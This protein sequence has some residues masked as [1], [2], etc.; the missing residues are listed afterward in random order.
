ML[1]VSCD[2]EVGELRREEPPQFAGALDLGE[3][4]GDPRLQFAVPARDLIGALDGIHAEIRI[5]QRVYRVRI[6]DLRPGDGRA[7][8]D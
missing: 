8:R 3:L 1:I 4:R 6:G 7:E 2:D 5:E